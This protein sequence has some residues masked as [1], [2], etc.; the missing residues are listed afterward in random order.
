MKTLKQDNELMTIL[1]INTIRRVI[2]NTN[3]GYLELQLRKG[4]KNYHLI[5]DSVPLEKEVSDKVMD[6]LFKIEI[7]NVNKYP[8]DNKT[9]TSTADKD[10]K[11][12]LEL[13]QVSMVSKLEDMQ[14]S[15]VTR[16]SPKVNK[17][18]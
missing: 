4:D 8:V 16:I 10:P 9:L 17:K 5:L 1:P 15:K 12:P 7:P 18:K 6:L 2:C 11:R 13:S 3:K 14:N